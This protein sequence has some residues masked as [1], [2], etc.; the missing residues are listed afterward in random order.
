MVYIKVYHSELKN[1]IVTRFVPQKQ[2]NAQINSP[3]EFFYWLHQKPLQP[4]SSKVEVVAVSLLLQGILFHTH[5]PGRTING[6]I[7]ADFS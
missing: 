4:H 1:A 2:E 7:D 3:Y 6:D 5:H